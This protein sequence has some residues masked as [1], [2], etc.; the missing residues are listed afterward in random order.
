MMKPTVYVLCGLPGSGKTT[1]ARSLEAGGVVRLTFAEAL[2]AK[3]G[4]A[5]PSE[6]YEEYRTNIESELISKMQEA[7][8]GG[9]NVVFDWG[10][11]QKAQRE[12]IKEA[13]EVAGG[14]Y[15]LVYFD[16]PS[17]EL[18]VAVRDRD[19]RVNQEITPRL[20]EKI[21]AE[22]EAPG[23]NENARNYYRG[24]LPPS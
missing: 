4:S 6:K 9:E 19:P 21:I 14:A 3:Y 20:M 1:Y 2:I 24:H 12:R 18:R 17:A 11:W 22:F 5:F 23:E 13:I 15:A 16:R 10:F 7:V 8:G